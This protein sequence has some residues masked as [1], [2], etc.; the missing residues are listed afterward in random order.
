MSPK[1]DIEVEERAEVI[2]IYT[3]EVVELL[4][5]SNMQVIDRI[6]CLFFAIVS[7]AIR[8]GKSKE[9]M[10][11]FIVLMADEFPKERWDQMTEES[12]KF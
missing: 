1:Y 2:N 11:E 7:F 8:C 3:R 4:A 9:E 10:M 5:N 6:T 12:G